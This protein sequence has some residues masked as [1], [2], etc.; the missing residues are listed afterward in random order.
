MSGE[1]AVMRVSQTE[2]RRNIKK[3]MD[4]V[5]R[6][7]EIEIC[8]RGKPIALMV[9]R[10]RARVPHWKLPREPLDIPDVSL[11]KAIIEDRR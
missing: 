2:L 4:A 3:Y 10:N 5:E 7:E 1:Q 9:P 11:S 6:G 8:R